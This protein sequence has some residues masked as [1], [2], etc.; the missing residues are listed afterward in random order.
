MNPPCKTC[1]K[2]T[3][4]W[5]WY[6]TPQE[7]IEYWYCRT[8][9]KIQVHKKR[10]NMLERPLYIEQF[11]F[12]ALRTNLDY[13][14]LRGY[15]AYPY[16]E[17]KMRKYHM[18]PTNFWPTQ[19]YI[20]RE[21]LTHLHTLYQML[22]SC[23][24]VDI[25]SLDGFVRL[26]YADH[27]RDILPPVIEL[28]DNK[29]LI[30]DGMHRLELARRMDKQISVLCIEGIDEK[31]P[32]YAYPLPNKWEGVEVVEHVPPSNQK[33]FH[34]MENYK[35]FYRDFNT[36]FMNVGDSRP[37]RDDSIVEMHN[38]AYGR[39]SSIP[40]AKERLSDLSVLEETKGTSQI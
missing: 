25:L 40:P 10:W 27:I 21:N 11:L 37:V 32:Y 34:R 9:D 8:C 35:D 7:D 15:D 36:A 1:R 22:L 4:R 38:T 29:W 23:H 2:P 12:S 3:L 19:T 28:W 26:H 30:C 33:K 17:T 14:R 24:N 6:E 5:G 20:L 39:S 18:R 16:Q 31:W 13:V